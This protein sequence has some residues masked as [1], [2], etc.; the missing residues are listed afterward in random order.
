MSDVDQIWTYGDV[1]LRDGPAFGQN[2][3]LK[4]SFQSP[5]LINQIPILDSLAFIAQDDYGFQ[6][7]DITNR[8]QSELVGGLL[9]SIGKESRAQYHLAHIPYAYGQK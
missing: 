6:I 3:E 5:G 1:E 7:I 9:E 4:G 8:V 2:F